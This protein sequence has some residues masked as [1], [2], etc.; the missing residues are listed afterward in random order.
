MSGGCFA[1]QVRLHDLRY[2]RSRLLGHAAYTSMLLR[3]G[4]SLSRDAVTFDHLAV[5]GHLLAS[6]VAAVL[7]APRPDARRLP[8]AMLEETARHWIPSD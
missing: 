4:R 7:L 3:S 5:K 1:F 6:H 8:I 2:R